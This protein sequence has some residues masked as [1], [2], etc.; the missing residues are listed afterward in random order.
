VSGPR[1]SPRPRLELTISG[2]VFGRER[3]PHPTNP[4]VKP[5]I[6]EVAE[7]AELMERAWN[8]AL[9]GK[10]S[11]ERDSVSALD[12]FA[13]LSRTSPKVREVPATDIEQLTTPS[14]PSSNESSSSG[15]PAAWRNGSRRGP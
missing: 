12:R 9:P 11:V 7:V 3:E 4:V 1:H 2:P 8:A 15:A 14:S 5:T 6:D 13:D 10:E